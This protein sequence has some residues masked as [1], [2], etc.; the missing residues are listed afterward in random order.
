VGDNLIS[1]LAGFAVSGLLAI[2]LWWLNSRTELK[3]TR[4]QIDAQADQTRLQIDAQTDQTR[5]PDLVRAAGDFAAEMR[6]LNKVHQWHM[7]SSGDRPA[8]DTEY[9]QGQDVRRDE[10]TAEVRLLTLEFFADDALR[11]AAETWLEAFYVAWYD[12]AQ[13]ARPEGARPE[14]AKD[15][16]ELLED[17]EGHYVAEVRRALKVA[18]PVRG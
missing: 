2:A 4:L 17:A 16:Y 10:P 3:K 12:K 7:E 14:G 13:G 11:A 6:R 18:A 5:Y 9:H 15:P 8:D 1:G